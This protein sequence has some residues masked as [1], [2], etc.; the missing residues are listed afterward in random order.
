MNRGRKKCSIRAHQQ[1]GKGTRGSGAIKAVI[2]IGATS[3]FHLSTIRKNIF[4]L[5]EK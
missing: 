4:L 5:V 1:E 2:K 3:P